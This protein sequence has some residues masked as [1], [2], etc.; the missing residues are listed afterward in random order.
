[1]PDRPDRKKVKKPPP[2]REPRLVVDALLTPP[3]GL[4]REPTLSWEPDRAKEAPA[5]RT[6]K[7]GLGLGAARELGF[8]G[9][10]ADRA[11][12]KRRRAIPVVTAL[13]ATIAIALAVV[14][15]MTLLSRPVST[16]QDLTAQRPSAPPARAQ[17]K[18]A[19]RDML[20]AQEIV[21]EPPPA[22]ASPMQESSGIE[23]EA[24]ANASPQ[25]SAPVQNPQTLKRAKPARLHPPPSGESDR[26]R[27]ATAPLQSPSSGEETVTIDGTTYVKGREPQALG[28]VAE[29]PTEPDNGPE[30]GDAPAATT[31][32]HA[33]AAA[34][35]SQ[36]KFVI[37]PNGIFTPFDHQ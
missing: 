19:E 16:L 15:T 17:A 35:P 22:T 7:A 10:P 11:R 34:G 20:P 28:T 23:P 24:T 1:M 2:S 8:E 5:M 31:P 13:A 3:A 33:P 32:D 25:A 9:A 30:P 21:A 4:P 14:G 37:M 27:A 29:A 26:D 6:A 36:T 12:P 18:T